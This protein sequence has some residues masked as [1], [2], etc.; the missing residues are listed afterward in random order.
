MA[1][2]KQVWNNG[3]VITAEKLNNLE[4]GVAGSYPY[5]NCEYSVDSTQSTVT[6]TNTFEE[7]C[8]IAEA[9]T[10]I[11]AFIDVWGGEE[12]NGGFGRFFV[13]AYADV[14]R[15]D[16][17]A[18]IDTITYDCS[19]VELREDDLEGWDLFAEKIKIVHT[20]D[21]VVF[22]VQVAKILS[23]DLNDK[24]IWTNED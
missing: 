24:W 1:Y 23:N 18:P 15:N 13:Y 3:D 2:T 5:I 14:F 19:A 11:K 9:G 17:D 16:E 7:L 4:N 22:Y 6:C 21:G 12:R 20:S 10:P 8:A